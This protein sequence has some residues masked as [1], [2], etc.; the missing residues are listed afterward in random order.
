MKFPLRTEHPSRAPLLSVRAVA[1]GVSALEECRSRSAS[2]S[3]GTGALVSVHD[4]FRE[5]HCGRADLF[6]T[7]RRLHDGLKDAVFYSAVGAVAFFGLVSWPAAA[8]IGT[9]HALHQRAR[10]VIR[11]GAVSEAR[12]GLIEAVDD[13]I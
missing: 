13:V 9:G 11:S 4:G 3:G 10:N 1:R 8:L 5:F 12:E 6:A 2:R 7:D